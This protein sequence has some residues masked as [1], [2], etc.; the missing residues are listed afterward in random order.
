MGRP[1]FPFLT[2]SLFRGH[3]GK[4]GEKSPLEGFQKIST[5]GRFNFALIEYLPQTEKVKLKEIFL[6]AD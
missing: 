5:D 2:G 1:E 3:L 4:G 6:K